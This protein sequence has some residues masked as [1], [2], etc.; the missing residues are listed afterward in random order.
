MEKRSA[1]FL[2]QLNDHLGHQATGDEAVD[3]SARGE[4]T[5]QYRRCYGRV[6]IQDLFQIIRMIA[7]ILVR[8]IGQGFNNDVAPFFTK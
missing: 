6:T 3:L 4:N 1:F 7:I 8:E 2:P 5:V